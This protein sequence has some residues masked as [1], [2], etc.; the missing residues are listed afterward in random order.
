MPRHQTASWGWNVPGIG[1]CLLS[2]DVQL[3]LTST[4]HVLSDVNCN[5]GFFAGN[6]VGAYVTARRA[7]LKASKQ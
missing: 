2:C 1:V 4:W 6:N 5:N 7:A 3:W